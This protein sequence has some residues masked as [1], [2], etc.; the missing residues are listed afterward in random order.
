MQD[1]ADLFQH[2]APF[3]LQRV[4]RLVDLNKPRLM[5][6]AVLVILVGWVPLALLALLQDGSMGGQNFLAFSSDFTVHARSLIACPLLILAETACAKELGAIVLQF[7]SDDLLPGRERPGFDI[8]VASTKRL[9]NS[10]TAE[11]AAVVA[12]Y[13]IAAILIF[14]MSADQLPVWQKEAGTA[15]AAF[16]WAGWWHALVSLPLLLVLLFG[17]MWKLGLWTRFLWLMSRL[18]LHLVAVHP[19]RLAGLKFIS[20]S[21]YGFLLV[22]LALATIVA[23]RAADILIDRGALAM[24]E[25]LGFAV[26]LIAIVVLFAGPLLVFAGVLLR[27]WQR[28]VLHYGAGASKFGKEFERKWFG[29]DRPRGEEVLRAPDFSAAADLY[30]VVANVYAMRIV[31]IDILSLILLVGAVLLPFVPVVLMTVPVDQIIVQ[32]KKLLL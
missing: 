32:L 24:T 8:A 2:C 30:Q 9:L 18:D 10:T 19:D 17:W 14:S 11:A 25:M 4:L 6:R 23:G 20:H 31:P 12:A 13:V 26:A 15:A 3:K 1:T 5:R 27:E 16:S 7:G 29:P 22:A 21:V 28:G